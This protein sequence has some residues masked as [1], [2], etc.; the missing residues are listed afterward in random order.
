MSG[1][2]KKRAPPRPLTIYDGEKYFDAKFSAEE[3][4]Q[5]RERIADECGPPMEGIYGYIGI[6]RA[7]DLLRDAETEIMNALNVY[8][9]P[10]DWKHIHV[11]R[12][13]EIDYKSFARNIPK[14]PI[15]P[16]Y[17]FVEPLFPHFKP[18]RN[19]MQLKVQ[20]GQIHHAFV[21]WIDE[22]CPQIGCAKSSHGWT[23]WDRFEKASYEV[24]AERICAHNLRRT[25]FTPLRLVSSRD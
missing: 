7:H 12:Q 2:R 3:R 20:T 5:I 22:V 6:N 8:P 18:A 16:F 14:L 23:C 15:E 11:C 13:L 4:E 25:K 24:A 19:A 9:V 10:S 1:P 17:R 21:D